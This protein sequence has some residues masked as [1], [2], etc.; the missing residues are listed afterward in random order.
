MP[1]KNIKDISKEI[2]AAV[3]EYYNEIYSYCL[4]RTNSRDDSFDITQSVFLALISNYPSIDDAYVRMWLYSTAKHKIADYFDELRI[5]REKFTPLH[6]ADDD[7]DSFCSLFE[8]ISEDEIERIK[9]V[10]I[11]YLSDGEKELYADRFIEEL[12]YDV[13]AQKYRIPQATVRKR[14]SRLRKKIVELLGPYMALLLLAG[15]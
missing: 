12:E 11:S 9:N 3:E 5:V 10:V 8:E 15:R 1:E 2:K 14:I 4:R 7:G 13:L 6:E